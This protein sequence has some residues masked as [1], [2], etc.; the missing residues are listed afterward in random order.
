M[1]G[2]ALEKKM[3]WG[4]ERCVMNKKASE[5]RTS[6]MF[7]G[8]FSKGKECR[9]LFRVELVLHGKSR[10]KVFDGIFCQGTIDPALTACQDCHFFIV[11]VTG[12][13][14]NRAGSDPFHSYSRS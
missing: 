3:G 5:R 12:G 7:V 2:V 6:T 4:D 8:L 9:C 14:R 11:T 13:S 1:N 10:R